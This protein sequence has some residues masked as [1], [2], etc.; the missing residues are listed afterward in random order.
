MQQSIKEYVI[1]QNKLSDE[2]KELQLM[3]QN[4]EIAES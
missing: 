3:L 2:T 1:Q 4:T